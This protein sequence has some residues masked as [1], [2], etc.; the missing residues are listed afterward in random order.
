MAAHAAGDVYRR[1]CCRQPV[2]EKRR[3]DLCE[4]L[5]THERTGIAGVARSQVQL[6][7][8]ELAVTTGVD[9]ERLI[10]NATRRDIDTVE[11]ELLALR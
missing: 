5:L 4:G 7:R 6:A 8:Y 10:D 1:A 3:L 11:I 9:G 2:G